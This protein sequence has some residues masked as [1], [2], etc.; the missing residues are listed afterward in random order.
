LTGDVDSPHEV[1]LIDEAGASRRF[2]VHDALDVEERTYYL[3][4]DAE[5]PERVLLL[6]ESAGG[7]ETIEGEEFD[8][9]LALLEAGD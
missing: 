5:D 4:E 2:L 3:V 7:L 9:V 1:V 6:K 8:R